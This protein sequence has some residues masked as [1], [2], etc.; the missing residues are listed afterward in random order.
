MKLRKVLFIKV[1]YK[2]WLQTELSP[3]PGQALLCSV[4]YTL[5]REGVLAVTEAKTTR[6]HLKDWQLFGAVWYLRNVIIKMF[7]SCRSSVPA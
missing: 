7:Y 3:D 5:I 2:S 4:Q 6:S 1:L